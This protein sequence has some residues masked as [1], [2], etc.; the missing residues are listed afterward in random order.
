MKNNL[1]TEAFCKSYNIAL[2]VLC[3]FI[4]LCFFTN[5]QAK[6]TPKADTPPPPPP[7]LTLEIVEQQISI[8]GKPAKIFSII[9]PDGTFGLTG[10]RDQLL[11]VVVKN[12]TH[13]WT[14]IHW[15][16]LI[17][18]NNQDGAPFVTQQPIP[19][20]G[21]F[22]YK[23]PLIQ[24]GT[25]W[26]H[27]PYTTQ[28]QQLM[29]APLI[30]HEPDDNQKNIQ[31]V[32]MLL[33]D[34]TFG[35][36]KE[37]YPKMRQQLMKKIANIHLS[38]ESDES[39]E[40]DQSADESSAD[41]TL[42]EIKMDAYLTNRR[43]LADPDIV[44][45]EPGSVVRLRIIDAAANSNF[46]INLGSLTGK[47]VAADS[48]AVAPVENSKFQLGQGQRLD[49][50]I[51]IPPGDNSYPI[52]AQAEGTSKQTGLVLAAGNAIVPKYS[53]N[54]E[55]VAGSLDYSQELNLKARYPLL[56]QEVNRSFTVNL[57]SNML[58]YI[59]TMNWQVWPN[60]K[61]L[62]IKEG[63]RD[64]IILNNKTAI[65][66]PVHLHGHV[67]QIVQIDDKKLQGAV[68]DTV[69]VLPYSSVTI[70]FDA[71]NPGIWL[72][73]GFVPYLTYGA[74]ATTV[75]YEGYSVPVFNQKDTGVPPKD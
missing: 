73:Q 53:E 71:D 5:V 50:D 25:F 10:V 23:F 65:P 36:P 49:I 20:D 29:A 52:L 44:R 34:Y 21:E 39:D 69:V 72:L 9:Q 24:S 48:E 62:L 14:A 75:N 6:K 30:I 15:H 28:L 18:P 37:V 68:R 33:Q 16:G 8:D 67:F 31:D 27:S 7:I 26:I 60:I 22:H 59:W 70:Q 3:F 19:P 61:P 43:T 45:V 64:Q 46:F 35:N 56:P 2:A 58:S 40:S 63:D 4:T 42:P 12:K 66:I 51:T 74:M 47:I 1:R 55:H 11:D 54:A 38:D 57:G 32:V 13:Q 41:T 17:I